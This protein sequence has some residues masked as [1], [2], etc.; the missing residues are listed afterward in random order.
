M[1]VGTADT[2]FEWWIGP[3]ARN[4]DFTDISVFIGIPVSAIAYLLLRAGSISQ[5]ARARGGRGPHDLLAIEEQTGPDHVPDQ[6]RTGSTDASGGGLGLHDE[7]PVRRAVGAA[8]RVDAAAPRTR[9]RRAGRR[10]A[11]RRAPPSVRPRP[12]RRPRP[13]RDALPRGGGAQYGRVAE[14]AA[15]ELQPTG[16]PSSALPIGTLIAG[17][18][19]RLAG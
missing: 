12:Q 10:A 3:I 4:L 11:C 2:K 5:G 9:I 14:P 18:P 7:L 1:V 8:H 6:A 13:R 15:G 16:R 19:V 17:A